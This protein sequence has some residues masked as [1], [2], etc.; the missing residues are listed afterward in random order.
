LSLD[1]HFAG[2]ISLDSRTQ[3]Y[4]QQKREA[5]TSDT[6]NDKEDCEDTQ[7][8]LRPR[9]ELIPEFVE[10]TGEHGAILSKKQADVPPTFLSKLLVLVPGHFAGQG[11][12]PIKLE[13]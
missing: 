13:K 12:A 1:C 8:R 11:I 5:I 6:V 9:R 3:D 7:G 4:F 2:R 10:G